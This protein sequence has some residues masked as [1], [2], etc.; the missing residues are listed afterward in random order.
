MVGASSSSPPS[1]LSFVS[2]ARL[3]P[4][5]TRLATGL[6]QV[7]TLVAELY[8][9]C[10]TGA[11]DEGRQLMQRIVEAL[12]TSRPARARTGSDDDDDDDDDDGDDDGDGAAAAAGAG[13]GGGGRGP[14]RV[15]DEDGWETIVPRGGGK[16]AAAA[17]AAPP[18]GPGGTG[19]GA[20]GDGSGSS[21]GH[22]PAAGAM[23]ED[24]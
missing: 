5:P 23:E 8:H 1:H 21:G 20:G 10:A 2:C 18:A 7:S 11:L 3:P 17:A 16:L 22:G 19:T 24:R 4:P 15:I 6:L 14:H 9:K 13:A 12:P